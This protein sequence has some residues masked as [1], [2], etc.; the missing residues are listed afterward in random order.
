MGIRGAAEDY[1]ADRHLLQA[2]Y[3]LQCSRCKP[4]E[5]HGD[6]PMLV[7]SG[8][9]SLERSSGGCRLRGLLE[10]QALPV[11]E[12]VLARRTKIVAALRNI[13]PGEGVIEQETGRRP[14]ET[15]GLTAYRALPMVVVLPDSVTQVRAVLAYCPD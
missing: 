6:G 13:V 4:P 12:T 14:Y 2:I 3:T 15:D 11:D 9:L 8:N 1:P 5:H 10:M 7:Q